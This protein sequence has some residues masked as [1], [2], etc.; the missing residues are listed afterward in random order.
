MTTTL[1][2]TIYKYYIVLIRIRNLIILFVPVYGGSGG[3]PDSGLG[4]RLEGLGPGDDLAFDFDFLQGLQSQYELKGSQLGGAPPTWTHEGARTQPEGSQLP[5]ASGGAQ[6][7]PGGLPGSSQEV[8]GSAAAMATPQSTVDAR[9]RQIHP[10]D[11]LTY[12]REKTHAA[13]RA[14]CSRRPSDARLGCIL[15]VQEHCYM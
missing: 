14:G 9:R 5:G 2:Q 13:V 1:C 10:R 15:S 7:S 12:P 6:P 3:T 4:G 11:P 8:A